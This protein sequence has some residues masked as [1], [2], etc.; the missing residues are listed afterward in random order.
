MRPLDEIRADTF[1]LERTAQG[2]LEEIMGE[3]GQ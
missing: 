3:H 1:A 2:L